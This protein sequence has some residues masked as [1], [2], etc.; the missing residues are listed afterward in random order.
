MAASELRDAQRVAVGVFEPRDSGGAR[1]RPDALL[2]LAHARI[3]CSRTPAISAAL[4]LR[5]C[6]RPAIPAS[7]IRP[8]PLLHN[9]DAQHRAVRLERQS[10]LVLADEAQAEDVA[11]E[12]LASAGL[13]VAANATILCEPDAVSVAMLKCHLNKGLSQSGPSAIS[14]VGARQTVSRSA[15]SWC[16]QHVIRFHLVLV[17]STILQW[18]T[19][20]FGSIAEQILSTNEPALTSS[21]IPCRCLVFRTGQQQ[22]RAFGLMFRALEHGRFD[23]IS[24]FPAL[25]YS[26]E[27]SV[28]WLPRHK[29]HRP[30]RRP[31]MSITS[32]SPRPLRDRR[33]HS[34]SRSWF[35]T[36]P[37]QCPTTSSCFG[38]RKG[39]DWDYVVISAPR[40]EGGGHGDC[41]GAYRCT[42]GSDRVA[43][44]YVRERTFVAEFTK[45]MS[46]GG[47]GNPSSLV[48]IVGVHRTVPGHREQLQ[49]ALNAAGSSSKIQTGNVFLQH[50]EGGSSWTF[51]TITRTTPG[52]ISQANGRPRHQRE[53][54]RRAAGPT[55]A[56]IPRFIATRSQTGS[57]RRSRA[58]Q[59]GRRLIGPG[60]SGGAF[61]ETMRPLTQLSSRPTVVIFPVWTA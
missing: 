40:A 37:R 29:R 1:R 24:S 8:R 31:R 17:K 9:R 23:E 32:T 33:Q 18:P 27:S 57:I 21:V 47:S 5:Q 46:I 61:R 41:A 4:P 56:S 59:S 26:A 58:P 6:P 11:V 34:A 25:S 22:P 16:N 51:A 36:R 14:T 2:V 54:R 20:S 35:L 50:L 10:E 55:S 30:H 43:Q 7:C 39:D 60:L 48:Y 52:R 44:R 42:A 49:K 15:S 3:R 28:R 45:Q 53:T 19:A 13:E 12:A 38:I